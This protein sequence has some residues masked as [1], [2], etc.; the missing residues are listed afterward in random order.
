MTLLL[1]RLALII[2]APLFFVGWLVAGTFSLLRVKAY[3][4]II[5]TR[6][7]TAGEVFARDIIRAELRKGSTP[8]AAAKVAVD[9]LEAAGLWRR[10]SP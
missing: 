9:A 4:D 5:T 10:H 1:K 2:A 8:E 3:F 6:S 7:L